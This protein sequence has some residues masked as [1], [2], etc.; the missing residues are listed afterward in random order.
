MSNKQDNQLWDVYRRLNRYY[1]ALQILY[2]TGENR[3]YDR[4]KFAL[5]VERIKQRLERLEKRLE[6][7]FDIDINQLGVLK[8]T[9][10]H[11]IYENSQN[12]N[13]PNE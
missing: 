7:Q 2:L 12:A 6:I 8:P 9:K 5:E 4:W 13:N 11:P 1:R 10:D 3:P